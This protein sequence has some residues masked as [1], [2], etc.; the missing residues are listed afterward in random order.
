VLDA[1]ARH[2]GR[3]RRTDLA[4]ASRP[5]PLDAGMDGP[6]RRQARRVRLNARKRHLAA[7]SSARWAHAIVSANDAQNRRSQ[8]SRERHI[9][10]MHAAIAAIESR[11]FQPTSD[12]LTRQERAERK[13]NRLQ[14]GYPTQAERFQKQRRLQSLQA[15]LLRVTAER[16]AGR[17]RITEGGKQLTKTRHNLEAAGLTVTGWREAWEAA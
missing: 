13:K 4:A 14:S 2:L 15:K 6:G 5:E 11:L 1:V 8:D 17:A 7:L 16:D 12:T 10:D 9:A 3:L